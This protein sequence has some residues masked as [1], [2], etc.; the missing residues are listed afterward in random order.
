MCGGEDEGR[1]DDKDLELTGN[2]LTE[3]QCEMQKLRNDR[4]MFFPAQWPEA[5]LM[6]A[7]HKFSFV[8]QYPVT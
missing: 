8:F 1:V 7:R 5:Y 2:M 4:P 3:R 6:C